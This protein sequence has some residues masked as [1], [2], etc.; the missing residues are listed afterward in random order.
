M[1]KFW[2]FPA[3]MRCLLIA[4]IDPG[5]TSAYALLDL[6]GN[7]IAKK[8]G[9]GLDLNNVLGEITEYGKIIAI[10]CDKKTIPSFVQKVAAR[11]NAKT[12]SPKEDLKV[13]EKK[14]FIKKYQKTE[15]S[16]EA[17]ALASAVFAYNSILATINKVRAVLKDE[18]KQ[19]KESEVIEI[20]L[21]EEIPI[22]EV[23]QLLEKPTPVQNEEKV[24]HIQE[25]DP[26]SKYKKFID[27]LE[28][29]NKKLRRENKKLKERLSKALE[30]LQNIPQK[31]TNELFRQREER[32]KSFSRKAEFLQ[33]I[34]G[35][36]ELKIKKLERIL[37]EKQD[38][39]PVRKI[40]NLGKDLEKN[41]DLI[42][43]NDLLVVDDCSIISENLVTKL[44]EKITTIIY[45][46]SIPKTIKE[47]LPFVFVHS[48]EVVEEDHETFALID[49]KKL[50]EEKRKLNILS[51]I[52]EEYE[53][54]NC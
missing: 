44:K 8:S 9:K 27:L 5:T 50:A 23:L 16:H 48:Q 46:K 1:Y 14:D 6:D 42:K 13:D 35:E 2:E 20:V 15:N 3:R 22:R 24:I 21:K 51:Q 7:L 52:I 36:K 12:F 19:E 18:N 45:Q 4:G 37:L 40:K 54:E 53:R 28:K 10:G 38:L 25:E 39:L 47:K 31:Q 29:Q 26:F 30:K 32:L 17:D 49:T 41:I 34:V 43:T 11:L 33:K